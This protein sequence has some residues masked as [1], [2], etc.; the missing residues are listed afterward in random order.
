M[1]AILEQISLQ[2]KETWNKFSAG[3][4]KWDEMA[5]SFIKPIGFELISH[6][7][8]K[9]NDYVLDVASGTGEPGLTIAK[10][11]SNG[12][13][14]LTDISEGMLEYASENAVKQGVRNFEAKI[15]DVSNLPFEDNT[16]DAVSC[17][18]GYMF[19]PDMQL[20]T[21]EI[22]RVLKPGGRIVTS[23]W[24]VPQKNLWVTALMDAIKA[25]IDL[26]P[27]TEGAPGIF[28]CSKSGFIADMFKSSGL[29]NVA[30]KDVNTKLNAGKFDTYWNFMTEVVAPAASALS[31]A[32]EDVKAN[33]K[34]DVFSTLRMKFADG[35]IAPDASAIIIYGEK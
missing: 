13:V 8:L 34:C 25:N 11:V 16:F 20:A 7:N 17:R 28:R 22:Y 14:I 23:V 19:F 10:I 32:S 15:C 3:W 24:G 5:M 12:K 35:N 30:E 29:K 4:R 21:H 33:V 26:L 6:L 31:Q 2:Q 1:E 27:V 18:F 9:T